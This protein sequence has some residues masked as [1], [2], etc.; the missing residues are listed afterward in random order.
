MGTPYFAVPSLEA[1]IQHGYDVAAVVSTP[2]K[3]SGRG[4]KIQEAPVKAYARQQGIPTLTPDKLNEESFVEALRKIQAQ[5]FVVVAFKKLPTQVWSMPSY[6]TLNLHASLLPDYRGA[7]PINWAIIN[8]EEKTGLTTFLIE[9]NIDTGDLLLQEEIALTEDMT[10]GELHDIMSKKGGPMLIKTL[11]GLTQNTLKPIPQRET[12]SHK[13]APKIF[14]ED[15]L[16]DWNQ[17]V[18]QIHNKIRGL[19][20]YPGAYTHIKMKGE[21]KQMKVL[22]SKKVE[23]HTQSETLQTIASKEVGIQVGCKNGAIQIVELQLEGK[24]AV[25]AAEFLNGL[26]N[27]V[28][29]IQSIK[30]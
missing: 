29:E 20:P 25:T 12:H 30:E 26:H 27:K 11:E 10:A 24:K 15:C 7:A 16:I 8:G 19:S 28:V 22:R 1:L 14:K 17:D 18:N 13:K 21:W 4:L 9:E 2:D 3:A 5:V 23:S 6:G